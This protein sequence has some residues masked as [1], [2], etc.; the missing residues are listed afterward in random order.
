MVRKMV[1]GSSAGRAAVLGEHLPDR[2]LE[3]NFVVGRAPHKHDKNDGQPRI[4]TLRGM[5]PRASRSSNL[6]L[7][8]IAGRNAQDFNFETNV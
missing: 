2:S 5:I 6:T 3:R 1:V 8:N 4:C 7:Y